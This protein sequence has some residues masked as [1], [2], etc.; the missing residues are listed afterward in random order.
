MRLKLQSADGQTVSRL[1]TVALLNVY[2]EDD[3]NLRIDSYRKYEGTYLHHVV[4]NK[5]TPT[6]NH[7]QGLLTSYSPKDK[8]LYLYISA[9]AGNDPTHYV[10][11]HKGEDSLW[12]VKCRRILETKAGVPPKKDG[13]HMSFASPFPDQCAGLRPSIRRVFSGSAN[14]QSLALQLPSDPDLMWE[15]H[16]SY[17]THALFSGKE[18]FSVWM[19]PGKAVF[20]PVRTQ[21]DS[22]NPWG[23]RAFVTPYDYECI[24]TRPYAQNVHK[25]R[26]IVWADCPGDD[27]LFPEDTH[28]IVPQ[29]KGAEAV[30][31]DN[32][33]PSFAGLLDWGLNARLYPYIGIHSSDHKSVDIYG[34][35]Y[36]PAKEQPF[37][38]VYAT[39]KQPDKCQGI[40]MVM[41]LPDN[42]YL[43]NHLLIDILKYHMF[44]YDIEDRDRI[45]TMRA[46][47]QGIMRVMAACAGTGRDLRDYPETFGKWGIPMTEDEL[48]KL[49]TYSVFFGR[50]RR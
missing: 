23:L 20:R 21:P 30:T 33:L 19:H 6:T 50:G 2:E 12:R 18:E 41:E 34:L 42:R 24:R 43:P 46:R 45:E 15:M 25:P 1:I 22:P 13:I 11:L 40:P 4:E 47:W 16:L 10:V 44:L 29:V 39:N 27:Q 32:D 9:W 17:L 48:T 5:V 37:V 49:D 31:F 26:C 3:P 35:S 38:A 36:D 28:H 7:L 8:T 14:I